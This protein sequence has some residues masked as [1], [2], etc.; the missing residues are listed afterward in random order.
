MNDRESPDYGR[1]YPGMRAIYELAGI[2]PRTAK[3]ARERL[4]ALG[5]IQYKASRGRGHRSSYS[6]PLVLGPKEEKESICRSL[7]G[8]KRGQKESVSGENVTILPD[9][10]RHCLRKKRAYVPINKDSNRDRIAERED[11]TEWAGQSGKRPRNHFGIN[12]PAWR[13]GKA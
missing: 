2:S 11:V 6:F 10:N 8:D 12:K 13:K 1:C 7:R 5:V 3:R 4:V 9:Q